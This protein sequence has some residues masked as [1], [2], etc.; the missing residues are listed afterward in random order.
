MTSLDKLNGGLALTDAAFAQNENALAVNFDKNAV[1]GYS[2][3]KVE[4]KVCDK[5]GHKA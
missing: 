5:C 4:V 3:S 2:G 1:A